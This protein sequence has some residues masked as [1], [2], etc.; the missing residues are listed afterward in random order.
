L[1][2]GNELF[3]FLG[4]LMAVPGAAVAKIFVM[5]GAAAYRAS[6]MFGTPSDAPAPVSP[7][8]AAV[9][10]EGES[11]S[12]SEAV[13]VAAAEPVAEAEPVAVA[14]A[15]PVAAEAEPVAEAESGAEGR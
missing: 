6:A 2:V 1:M 10:A 12:E 7:V 15:E 4:V 11:E 8:V 13:S 9:L 3:G 5:R 14:V